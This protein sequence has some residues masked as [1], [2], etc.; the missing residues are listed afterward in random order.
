MAVRLSTL[1]LGK[2]PMSPRQ[3]K[4]VR[5]WLDEDWEAR[6]IDQDAV[7]L[8]KRL[9]VTIGEKDGTERPP[10]RAD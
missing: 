1:V 4:M 8:I 7:A 2:G 6:D 3:L 9:L 5:K 10:R